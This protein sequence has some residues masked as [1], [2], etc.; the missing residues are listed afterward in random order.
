[1]IAIIGVVIVMCKSRVA[2]YVHTLNLLCAAEVTLITTPAW[3]C[4]SLIVTPKKWA[5]CF[6]TYTRQTKVR[7]M[8]FKLYFLQFTNKIKG[9][10]TFPLTDVPR[11]RGLTV[12]VPLRASSRTVAET[13][14]L[15]GTPNLLQKIRLKN[16]LSPTHNSLLK[17]NNNGT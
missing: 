15:M 16:Q 7:K 6:S 8:N 5:L 13:V 9:T 12:T 17:L 1:M 14:V 11:G 10:H 2:E 3:A 4:S